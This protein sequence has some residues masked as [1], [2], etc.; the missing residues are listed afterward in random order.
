MKFDHLPDG[1]KLGLDALSFTAL[2]GSLTALLPAVASLLTIL[3]TVIRIYETE[4]VQRLVK[5]K[6]PEA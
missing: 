1:I 4:T 6:E 3:W 5:R 2:L